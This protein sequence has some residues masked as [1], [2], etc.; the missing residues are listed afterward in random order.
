MNFLQTPG[1]TD[2]FTQA[3]LGIFIHWGLYAMGGRHEWLMNREKM[4]PEEYN[5]Y[6]LRFDPDLYDPEAWADQAEKAGMKYFVVTT[7]HHE[8]FC[9]WDS[10]H[11][12]FKATNTPA[13][14]DL[15]RPMVEAFSKRGIRTGFYY[16]L[17]DWHHPHYVVDRLTHPQ[18]EVTDEELAELNE[19][20][21][22]SIYAQYMR[23]QVRE[24][25][26]EFGP[27]DI[28]WCDFSMVWHTDK[29]PRT[30]FVNVKGREAWESEKLYGMIRE[31]APDIILTNRLDLEMPLSGGD[32]LTPEQAQPR[33]WVETE[34]NGK[35]VPVTWEACQTFSGSWGYHRDEQTWRSTRQLIST[36]ID[37]VS[38]GGNLLLNVG[39]TSRGEFDQRANDRL[40]GIGE[41]M[42]RH[43][44]AIYGCTQAPEEFTCP[45]DCRL[46]YNPKTKRLYVHMLNWPYVLLHLDGQAYVDRVEYAQFLHDGS[47]LLG[48][49]DWLEKQLQLAG[50]PMMSLQIPQQE[51][52]GVEVPV[53]E[54][55]LK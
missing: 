36:L 48:P 7:K 8:G 13:G 14:R 29:F 40:N 20:R 32:I 30:D 38:K 23:D 55:F 46:T 45:E 21:D 24:L 27:V 47:E 42:K 31:L 10:K 4:T 41:W 39:P 9:M 15:I 54:L 51:P 18:R 11:T 6:F 5:R 17:L 35:Q 34:V 2:W 37:S 16:S 50:Q 3:R 26:T 43:S 33:E 44:R 52:E 19:D 49:N 12:D 22:Q 28:L 25:L 1:K 53:V